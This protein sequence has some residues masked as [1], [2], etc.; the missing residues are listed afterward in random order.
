MWM[1]HILSKLKLF[2]FNWALIKSKI[3]NVTTCSKFV[4]YMPET[5]ASILNAL[6]HLM[7]TIRLLLSQ[8]PRWDLD[9]TLCSRC[10]WNQNSKPGRW[11]WLQSPILNHYIL[12]LKAKKKYTR[13]C[14]R[15]AQ[16][17][18]VSF[19]WTQCENVWQVDKHTLYDSNPK[20]VTIITSDPKPIS[21]MQGNERLAYHVEKLLLG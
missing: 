19:K 9:Y 6:S 11:P 12:L 1:F 7:P 3:Q 4:Y 2:C 17:V 21:I 10:W 13:G 8:F 16:K 14:K 20:Q 5:V 18:H 15:T